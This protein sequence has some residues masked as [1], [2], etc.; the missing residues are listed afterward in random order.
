VGGTSLCTAD[1]GV[2]CRLLVVVAKVVLGEFSASFAGR[3]DVVDCVVVGT[4]SPLE[5]K[6]MDLQSGFTKKGKA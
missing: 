4:P 1:Y 5:D 2:R 6:V 3:R